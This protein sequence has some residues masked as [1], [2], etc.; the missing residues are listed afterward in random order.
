VLTHVDADHINGVLP[1][2]ANGISA[3]SFDDIWFNGWRQ[4]SPFLSI[5]QGEEFSRLLGDPHRQLRWNRAV[6]RVGAKYPAPVVV[7]DD[8]ELPVLTLP[9]GMNL[10]LLSPGPPQ[11]NRLGREWHRA[12]AELEEKPKM[13][14]RRVPP[15][16]VTDFDTFDVE[17]L[18]NATEH[19][20]SSV[21][22]GSS[23]AFVAEYG[24]RSVLFTGDAHADVLTRSIAAFQ[25]QRGRLG[26]PLVL[27]A[28]KLSHH[29]SRNATTV[30]LL[31]SIECPRYLVPTNGIIFYHPDREAIARI[32]KH[33]GE[34]PTI[35][36]NYRS[37]YNQLWED[38]RL[39]D[40][41]QYDTVYPDGGCEGLRVSL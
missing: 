5:R 21:P 27:D 16:P 9:G 39:R 22:N 11:L 8:G 17:V 14:G 10:T 28:L 33:G 35:Y 7:P 24:G 13:L 3:T 31:K 36:F 18:A 6:T 38:E 4:V 30:E 20:D 1:L 29:G 15:S 37:D 25:R 26:E 19:K 32:I 34:R 12:L 41:Y 2:F 23:I 40:R